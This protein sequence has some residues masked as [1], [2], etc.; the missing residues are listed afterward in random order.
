M[1]SQKEI[2]LIAQEVQ[3]VVPE[4]IGENS[5]GTLSLDYPKLTALLIEST[6]E[7]ISRL[8]FLESKIP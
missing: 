6:K 2:G 8:E 5:D 4:V 3:E 7:L 1:G